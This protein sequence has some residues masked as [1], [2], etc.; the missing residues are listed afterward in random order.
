MTE[1]IE[2]SSVTYALIIVSSLW[3]GGIG[4]YRNVLIQG[5]VLMI[6]SARGV[7]ACMTQ[8]LMLMSVSVPDASRPSVLP[9]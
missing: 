3:F 7:G 5:G 6:F 2:P 4:E 1:S 8:S 9:R